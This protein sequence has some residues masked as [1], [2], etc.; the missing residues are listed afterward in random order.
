MRKLLLLALACAPVFLLGQAQRTVLMEEWTNASCVPCAAQNPA[1]NV[2]LNA[3]TDNVVAIKYQWYF[4]GYDPFQEQNPTEINNRGEYYGLNGVPTAWMDGLAPGDSYGGGIGAWDV[5][6]GNGYEG[7]PYGYNQAVLDYAAAQPTPI[8]MTVTHSLNADVTEVTI[9][10]AITNLSTTDF[11][12]ADG[13]LHIVL[14]EAEVVFP[15]PPGSTNEFEFYDVMRKMYP[16]ENGSAVP[17]IAAGATWEFS[18]TG[19]VPSYIYG[20]NQLKVAA[21]VQDHTTTE[22]WQAAVTDV[23]EIANAIDAGFVGNLTAAPVGLCGATIVPVVEFA[24][25]GT[26]DITQAQLAAQINGTTVETYEY[27]GTLV[28]DASVQITFSEL[29]LT[30]ANNELAFVITEVNNGVGVDI[31]SLNNTTPVVTYSALSETPIG[32]ELMETNETYV[33]EY[34]T[35]GLVTPSIPLGEF[36]GNSFIVYARDELTATA[37]DPIGG[38]GLSDRSIF[39]NFYQWNPAGATPDNA[40]LTYQKIDLAGTTSPALTFDRASVSYIGD[41]VSSDRLQVLIST[42]CAATFTLLWNAQGAALNTAPAIDPFYT[43]SAPD[44][45]TETIDLSAYAGEEVNIRFNA[46][47]GWGNNLFLDNINV[48]EVVAT[49]ELTEVSEIILFPNPVKE[50]MKVSFNLQVASPLQVEVFNAMGQR[51]QSLGA[52]DYPAGLNQLDIDASQLSSGIY[53]LRMFNAD[54]E[55]NRRFV[56][57]H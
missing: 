10:V 52:S 5:A 1:F 33:L 4:P 55:L 51:V 39:I 34:P 50:T 18:I 44:W 31:N 57:Q 56:V 7:G 22:V 19:A 6:S 29:V 17:T 3:N 21:F 30:A 26:V 8:E 16:N 28:P 38:Y 46:I 35:A 49:E 15:S 45:V 20:L 47:S 27:T 9:N 11:T 32:T 37:G 14:L 25:N 2:L 43:P 48:S 54:R 23:Q 41:G 24:N 36:G 12:M 40:S 13:R 53:F 42:D